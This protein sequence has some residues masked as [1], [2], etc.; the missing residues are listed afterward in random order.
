MMT[1]KK[2]LLL[3]FCGVLS[4][5]A[6]GADYY[7]AFK[8]GKNKNPGTKEAP[9]KNLWKAIEKA[10]PGDTIH[11]AGGTYPGKMGCGWID[12][13]KPVSII[14]GY[15]PDFS[16]R[17]LIGNPT[18]LRPTNKQNATKPMFGTMTIEYNNAPNAKMVVDGI[19]FD[20]TES[21]SYH[22]TKGKPEG[23]QEGMLMLPP[24]KGTKP[25]VT[26]D[27]Y[28]LFAKTDGEFVVQN[29]LFLNG[30][31][32]ALN[33][34][35]FSGSVKVLNNVFIGARMVAA[36]VHSRNAKQFAT[37]Y[38]FAYNTV[39]FTWTRTS[40]FEDMGFGVRTNANIA[41]N[42][43]HNLIGLNCMGGYDN[44]KGNDKTKKVS[45]DNNVFFLNKKADVTRT[46]SPS[47]QFLKVDDDGFEDIA[48]AE[49]MESVE[50]N[51]S[52][53]DPAIFKDI[54]DMNYLNAFLNATYTEKT[55]YDPNSPANVFRS[56]LGMNTR[57]TIQSK[58]SMFANP[59]PYDSA[60]KFFGA[61]KDFGAQV[62]K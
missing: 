35:H 45:L 6:F 37:S 29:C 24:A 15:K 17:D 31:N 28:Q 59:Y 48:D 38:E 5:S 53:Q 2:L 22:G 20:H 36:E 51:V 21:N 18:L 7:V 55:D 61:L 47:I 33:V 9:F 25:N 62:V 57:G 10:A 1:M 14:G 52:L 27:K 8:G 43:H 39:L 41:A 54:I 12:V 46:Q 11:V 23:F 40:S 58:V 56:A 44:T 3:A 16:G 19:F 49:G 60:V 50:G 30:S 34:A 4:L 26:M 13:K 42:V 32:Y